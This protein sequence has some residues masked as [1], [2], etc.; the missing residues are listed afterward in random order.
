MSLNA[1]IFL[2]L[3][4][5]WRNPANKTNLFCNLMLGTLPLFATILNA[6]PAHEKVLGLAWGVR[7]AWK[8]EGTSTLI[9]TGEAVAPGSL[10]VPDV[11]AGDHSI[12][13]LLPDGQSVLY[14]CF[15]VKD[16]A[17]GFRVPALFRTPDSF[18]PEMLMRIRASLVQREREPATGPASES[19]VARDEAVAQLGP[20]S[21]I[22]IGGLAAALSNGEYTGDLRSFDKM[23]PEQP[24]IPLEKSARTIALTVPGPGL[25]SL[26]IIDST[27]RPRINFMVAAVNSVQGGGVMDD[28]KSAHAL[29]ADW[30][31]DFFG[32]PIH[33]F[34]RAYLQSLM[35]N[36]NSKLDDNHEEAS[37]DPSQP[38]VVAEPIFTPHPGE[39]AEDISVALQC[40]TPGAIMHYTIDS[41]QPT[42][43]SPV[44]R[45]PIVM[46][47]LSL[48]VKAFAESPGIK[49]S[50]VVTGVFLIKQ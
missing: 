31:E 12:T 18:T 8:V 2:S 48:R 24:D 49:D 29:M 4:R 39:V 41:S 47:R 21:R 22:E 33:D 50:P 40:A 20:G 15:T 26:T 28:F 14:E 44:Y 16:C 9:R 6:Q 38:G 3:L 7:G 37:S 13:I 43:T 5:F 45:A 10:L 25:Y 36:I 46:K 34:Q 32:W 42:E 17:R 1:H 30:R 19:H 11:S 23:Y 27:K 35:L